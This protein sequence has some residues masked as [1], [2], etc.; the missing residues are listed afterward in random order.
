M[1]YKS[2]KTLL[3]EKMWEM[4][5][6]ETEVEDDAGCD[7]F[8]M[9]D[10]TFIAHT[11]WCVSHDQDVANLVN[12]INSLNGFYEFINVAEADAPIYEE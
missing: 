3:I 8:T 12:A 6:R 4:V 10:K 5:L 11:D 1:R 9:N 2:E 7:W